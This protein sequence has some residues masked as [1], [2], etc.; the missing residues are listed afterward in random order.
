MILW[1]YIRDKMLEHPYQK[2]CE[3]S[4]HLTYEDV[5]VLAESYAK[6]LKAPYYAL[7]CQSELAA[8]IALL[9]CI[10]AEKPVIPLPTRYGEEYY[11][12]ILNRS[13]PPYIIT[14]FKNEFSEIPLF[15]ESYKSDLP[16]STAVILFTS[17]STGEPKGVMLSEENIISNIKDII[18]YFPIDHNDTILISRPLYHSSVLTGEFLVSLCKGAKIVF[19]SDPFQPLGI[20]ELL[21]KHEVTVFGNTPTMMTM[22]SKFA[23]NADQVHIKMLSI[24]G[25]C[26]TE[27]MAKIIRKAFPKALIYCG[28]GLSEA[29]PRVAYLPACMFNLFPT[30]AGIPLPHVNL[31]IVNNRG[32]A[33]KGN[34]I[35]ELI[36]KGPN[37]MLGYFRDKSRTNSVIRNGW[38]YTGDLARWEENGM[39]R[40]VGRKDDMII[41]AGMNI[42]P[43]EIENILSKDKRVKDILVYKFS[44]NGTD[45]IGLK[46]CGDFINT[47]EVTKLCREVLPSFQMPFRIEL[48]ENTEMLSGGKKRRNIGNKIST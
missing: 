34:K 5:C 32:R 30:Y 10:A 23:K 28:Y 29:A 13:Q 14:D 36:V 16:E 27:G 12:K 39:L 48:V 25:E 41:R 20:L 4:S 26:M 7:L 35:G 18:S 24:S 6:K 9:A 8:A 37:V 21:R 19:S 1:K 43:A 31:K 42:Y 11:T 40:I 33:V 47:D 44:S 15:A 22:F 3:K 45:E 17:G 46:I 38:L 2:I